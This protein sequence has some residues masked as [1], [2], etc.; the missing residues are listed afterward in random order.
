MT[1]AVTRVATGV[2]AV[3]VLLASTGAADDEE[4]AFDRDQEV[5]IDADEIG[6]DQKR[7]TV[8]AIGD[9]EIRHGDTVLRAERVEVNR[10]TQDAAAVGD[11]VLTNPN[12]TIR[13]SEMEINLVDETGTLRN[14]EMQSETLGYS[15]WGEVIEKREGQRYRIEN[16]SFTTCQCDDPDDRLPWS[17]SG[18]SLDVELGGYGEVRGGRFLI[19]DVPVLYLPRAAFPVSQD[20]QAGLLFPRLGF[21]NR[22]GV[23]ILQP[24]YWPINKSQDAT[25][26]FDVETAQRLGLIVEHRY[27]IDR[28]SGGEMQVMYFNEAIRGRATEVSIPGSEDV[29]VP[30]NRWGVVGQHSYAFGASELY[31]DLLLVGDDVFL[32][33]INT[34][35]LD[36]AE[37][38]TLRTRPFTSSR[39]GGIHSWS[40]GYGQVE[41]VFHQN[42]VGREAYVF[43]SAPRGVAVGQK[44]L[45]AGFLSSIDSSVVNFERSTGITGT[46]VDI[47]PRLELQLPLGRSLDGALSTALRETAYVLTQDQMFGGFNGEATGAAANTLIDLPVTSSREAV[48]VRGHI[49]TG[50]SRVFDFP[51]WGLAKL[52]HTIEPQ[53]EYLYIPSIDQTDHPI[54]DGDDRLPARNVFSYGVASRVLGKRPSQVAPG[55]VMESDTVF[56]LARFTLVQSYDV[57]SEVP[58]A[59]ESES[60]NTFSDIDFG[61]RVAAGPSTSLRFESTYDPTR[62]DLTSATVALLT[63]EPDWL[64]PE[65]RWLRLLRR[66]SFGLQ[67]RFIANNSVPG[68]SAVE[69]LDGGFL[70]RVTEQVGLRY[71]GRYNIAASRLLSNFFGM[72]YISACDCW[73]VEVGLSDKSNP[74]EVQLQAQVNLLGFG[75]TAGGSRAGLRQ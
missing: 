46:R 37:D 74:N 61:M 1:S 33:E 60:R 19:N 52:K 11:A 51:R 13:A 17:V 49:G 54:F 3:V 72:S 30:E 71:S 6:Y 68:T 8:S 10:S 64:L 50:L 14:V 9:V 5:T 38:V 55:S 15:L 35:T 12:V 44:Q 34:F 40:R 41:G 67:Y 18:D 53:M 70:L 36:D 25:L 57:R 31:T 66:S 2:L 59:G 29:E 24:L 69:Q 58:Q 47:A 23:Q 39:L 73:S 48:E 42:L 43:Q 26:S 75:S 56:E 16:G 21:S 45:G 7:D 27:A 62:T 63:R 22:R 28:R 32:R 65:V 20:R 4:L